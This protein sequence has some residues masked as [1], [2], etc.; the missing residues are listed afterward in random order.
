MNLHLH[1]TVTA[2]SDTRKTSICKKY[3]KLSSICVFYKH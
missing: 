2:H 1:D 3:T